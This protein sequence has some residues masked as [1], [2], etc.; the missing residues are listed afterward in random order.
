MTDS[1]RPTED[2]GG[3]GPHVDAQLA[4]R[5]AA[6]ARRGLALLQTPSLLYDVIEALAFAARIR[7]RR[8]P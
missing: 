6:F 8:R 4:L 1:R 3:L 2:A 5:S 7:G